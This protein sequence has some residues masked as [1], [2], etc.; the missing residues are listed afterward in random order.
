L[1]STGYLNWREYLQSHEKHNY[2]G[3]DQQPRR[4]WW[5]KPNKNRKNASLLE[6]LS[7]EVRNLRFWRLGWTQPDIYA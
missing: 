2:D 4:I 6:D 7:S 5:T 3:I 1:E